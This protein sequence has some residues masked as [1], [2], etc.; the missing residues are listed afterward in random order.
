M[1]DSIVLA[2]VGVALGG[3]GF[4]LLWGAAGWAPALGVFLVLFGNNI[5]HSRHAP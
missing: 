3:V 2:A 1:K 5:Q 4:G